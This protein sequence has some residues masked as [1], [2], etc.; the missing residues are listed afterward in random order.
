MRKR[1]DNC[2]AK[3]TGETRGV[4]SECDCQQ[5]EDDLFYAKILRK[6]KG[7]PRLSGL[8]D[9]VAGIRR[10]RKGVPEVARQNEVPQSEVGR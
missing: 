7:D 2:G 10:P 4:L 3:D 1:L 6:V 5:R 8:G 9:N